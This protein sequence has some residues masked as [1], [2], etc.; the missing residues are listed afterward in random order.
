MQGAP[1]CQCFAYGTQ[2]VVSGVKRCRLDSTDIFVAR[3]VSVF[4]T[5]LVVCGT[6]RGRCGERLGGSSLAPTRGKTATH[7]AL[8]GASSGIG[9]A[10]AL[11]FANPGCTLSLFARR[12]A[13]LDDIADAARKR[14]AQVYGCTGDVS[15][16]EAVNTWYGEADD[17]QPINLTIANAG[18]FDG[19]GTGARLE[20]NAETERLVA[21]NLLGAIFTAQAAMPRMM[22]RRSGHIALVSSLAARLPAADAPTYSATKAG[23]VAYAEALREYLLDYNICVSTILPGHVRTAQTDRHEGRTPLIL[24]AEEAAWRIQRALEQRRTIITLPRR[25]AFL[26]AAARILPWRLRARAN[27]GSRFSVRK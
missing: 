18:I 24:T 15:D 27:A 17:R 19:H 25:A 4:D 3:E 10:L 23:L 2:P 7:V 12:K 8:T 11:G 26:V 5:Q 21:T 14:G 16:A 22:A 6:E 9:A 1:L 13:Q 20:T